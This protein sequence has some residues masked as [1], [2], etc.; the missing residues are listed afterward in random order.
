MMT[1]AVGYQISIKHLNTITPDEYFNLLS[2]E[3]VGSAAL[4]P[5]CCAHLC[6][7]LTIWLNS[8][9]FRVAVILQAHYNQLFNPCLTTI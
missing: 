9:S 8:K 3:P 5:P 1:Q 2:W 4:H 6:S 7:H